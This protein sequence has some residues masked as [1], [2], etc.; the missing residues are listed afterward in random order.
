M[1]VL[2]AE[3]PEPAFVCRPASSD[4]RKSGEPGTVGGFATDDYSSVSAT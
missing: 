4:N 1:Y 3:F 2:I